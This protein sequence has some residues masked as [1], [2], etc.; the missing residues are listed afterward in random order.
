MTDEKRARSFFFADAL[1]LPVP[2]TWNMA[3]RDRKGKKMHGNPW[4]KT[5]QAGTNSTIIRA[6]Q[7]KDTGAEALEP[8]GGLEGAE[9]P[10][11]FCWGGGLVVYLSPPSSRNPNLQT[12]LGFGGAVSQNRLGDETRVLQSSIRHPNLKKWVFFPIFYPLAS[13]SWGRGLQPLL[14]SEGFLP[15]GLHPWLDS[16]VS[17]YISGMLARAILDF[18][19]IVDAGESCNKNPT[20]KLKP[21]EHK[22]GRYVC[23]YIHVVGVGK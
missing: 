22:E 1:P 23:N 7:C 10:Q 4:K 13:P 9:P 12:L 5:G 2:A 11:L 18:N 3:C 21:Q 15:Y 19:N 8:G 16:I 6:G 17:L 20:L 14:P